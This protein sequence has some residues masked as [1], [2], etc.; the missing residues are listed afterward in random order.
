MNPDVIVRAAVL[1]V[2]AAALAY[3][4]WLLFSR[5]LPRISRSG[6]FFLWF[7]AF[8]ITTGLFLAVVLPYVMAER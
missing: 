2:A 6:A 1:F 8:A 5:R 4:T 3:L 7:W